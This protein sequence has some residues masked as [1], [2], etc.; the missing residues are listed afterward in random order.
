M[1]LLNMSDEELELM[2]K[3]SADALV[4]DS[5][6]ETERP[7]NR[8]GLKT[9]TDLGAM[10]REDYATKLTPSQRLEVDSVKQDEFFE[11]KWYQAPKRAWE[12]HQKK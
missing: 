10:T 5:Q 1:D 6:S 8:P 9:A 3:T 2:L 11:K 4:F 12:L 7:E